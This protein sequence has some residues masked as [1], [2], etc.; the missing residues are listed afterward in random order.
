MAALECVERLLALGLRFLSVDGLDTRARV[1]CEAAREVL[2]G[3]ARRHE[4]EERTTREKVRDA[5]CEPW[6]LGIV[7]RED[8]D[9]LIDVLIRVADVADGDYTFERSGTTKTGRKGQVPRDHGLL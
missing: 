7:T 4:D 5:L 8:F 1:A 9:D 2:A 6:P 3:G